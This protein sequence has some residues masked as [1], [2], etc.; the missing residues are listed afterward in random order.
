MSLTEVE[1]L[2]QLYALIGTGTNEGKD[3]SRELVEMLQREGLIRKCRRCTSQQCR[4]PTKLLTSSSH[5]G[6]YCSYCS[7]C[8]RRRSLIIRS[9]FENM[10]LSF[11]N[12]LKLMYFWALNTGV[13]SA[14]HAT[15]VSRKSVAHYFGYFRDICSWKM[16]QDAERF[17]FGGPDRVVQIDR[18][19]VNIQKYDEEGVIPEKWLLGIYD[20]FLR[21]GVVVHVCRWPGQTLVPLIQDYVLPG[22]TIY[23]DGWDAY[24]GLN[25]AGY[26]HMVVNHKEDFVDPTTGT[27]TNA[28]EV[29]WSKLKKFLNES[30]TMKGKLGPEHIDEFMW[31]DTYCQDANP[32]GKIVEAIR[33][34]YPL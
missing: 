6:G 16:L 10:T 28:V 4:S 20:T 31:R 27:C 8:R 22:T 5:K 2:D 9:F 33:E 13:R 12:V 3:D 26:K 11:R 19:I 18:S 32:F 34:R 15:G 17:K 21:R 23:T 24:Q 29:Y 25:T 7:R 30:I 1:S 14:V